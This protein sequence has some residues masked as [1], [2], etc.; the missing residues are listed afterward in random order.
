MTKTI[1][2]F[3]DTTV[4]LRQKIRFTADDAT[5]KAL[6]EQYG[7]EYDFTDVTELGYFVDDYIGEI[8]EYETIGEPDCVKVKGDRE[9]VEAR[10]I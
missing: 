1:E 7:E 4:V 8:G 3:V 9:I 5:I 10:I 6:I 2:A